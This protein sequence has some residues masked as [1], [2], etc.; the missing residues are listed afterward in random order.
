[1][2]GQKWRQ[3]WLDKIYYRGSTYNLF[4][5]FQLWIFQLSIYFKYSSDTSTFDLFWIF[6][7]QILQLSI[8]LDISTL[9]TSTFDLLWKFQLSI[10]FGYSLNTS[11]FYLLWIFRISRLLINYFLRLKQWNCFIFE[12]GG[13]MIWHINHLPIIDWHVISNFI[14][15]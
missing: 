3:H 1:M 9:D 4:Q 12:S 7:L 13:H 6:Q 10:Y 11:I 15:I 5:I 2:V 14:E 8:T